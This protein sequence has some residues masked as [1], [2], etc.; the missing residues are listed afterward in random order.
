M[1]ELAWS[2][3]DLVAAIANYK[4]YEALLDL[5]DGSAPGMFHSS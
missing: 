1:T 2:K 5:H 3:K 4:G